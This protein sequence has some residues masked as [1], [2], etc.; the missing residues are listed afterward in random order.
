VVTSLEVR[1]RAPGQRPEHTIDR[2]VRQRQHLV[3][4]PLDRCDERSLVAEGQYNPDTG[5]V[6]DAS[7]ADV[8]GVLGAGIAGCRRDRRRKYRSAGKRRTDRE[9]DAFLAPAGPP[10]QLPQS[11]PLT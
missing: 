2:Q 9:R 5:T 7:T 1:H 6:G 11:S 8:G 3:Q 10:A 4:P